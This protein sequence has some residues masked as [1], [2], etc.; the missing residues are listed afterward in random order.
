MNNTRIREEVDKV[1]SLFFKEAIPNNDY[2]ERDHEEIPIRIIDEKQ[3]NFFIEYLKNSEENII[4]LYSIFMKYINN[5]Q[6]KN[7]SDEEIKDDIVDYVRQKLNI[8]FRHPRVSEADFLKVNILNYDQRKHT[9]NFHKNILFKGVPGTGKSHAIDRI[10]EERLNLKDKPDNVLKIN[11][12]SASSNADLMQ[13]IAISTENNSVIY[14]EKQGLIMEHIKKACFSPYQPFVLVL[15]E[16][17]EN[18]LNELIGDLI[19]L[20]E[21]KKRAKISTVEQDV[22]TKEAYDYQELIDLYSDVIEGGIHTVKIPDLVNAGDKARRLIMPDNLYIFCT[23]NYRDDKKVIEDNLLRRFEVIELYPK[24]Q[25]DIF[26]SKQVST[27]LEALNNAILDTFKTREIHPDRFLIGHANWLDLEDIAE[28]DSDE[29]QK[30]K[31]TGFY[32]ALLKVVIEFKEIREIDFS[33]GLK[34]IFKRIEE[35]GPEDN[36]AWDAFLE[37]EHRNSGYKALVDELQGKIYDFL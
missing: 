8:H 23:S 37:L 33:S 11:I 28:G 19:Y 3:L 25:G 2:L 35:E 34:K 18:S 15:E 6:Y 14:K 20:I 10:I 17:Q 9:Q 12:H 4:H 22:F 26:R 13:G 36:W 1:Y 21:D 32:S 16:I 31:K 7:K 27:F 29:E 24:T 30:K 5:N